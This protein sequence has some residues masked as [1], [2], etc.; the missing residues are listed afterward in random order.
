[1]KAERFTNKNMF[2]ISLPGKNG[3]N[4]TL[5][6]GQW[7]TDPWFSRFVGRGKLSREYVADGKIKVV[8]TVVPIQTVVQ[9]AASPDE[10]TRDWVKKR[11]I[12]YCKH[13]D[14][15]RTGSRI[16]VT[17]H[18]RDMHQMD[19][20]MEAVKHQPPPPRASSAVEKDTSVEEVVRTT[21]EQ[22]KKVDETEST[23]VTSLPKSDQFQ[24]T[25]DDL[26]TE[27]AEEMS[28]SSSEQPVTFTCDIC[29]KV[30][31][32]LRGLNSHKT[33]SH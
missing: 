33:K 2:P 22:M 18:L 30:F 27:E 1:M 17:I 3:G 32:T 4:F 25:N 13:C 16:A 10:E 6:P 7:V 11:G 9:A 8:K 14:E 12:F 31:A 23:L 15:F 20:K 28:P 21:R 29:S 19:A 26:Q 5:S 24:L